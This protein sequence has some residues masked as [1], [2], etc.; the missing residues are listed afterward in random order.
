MKIYN[1]H[2]V[3][4]FFSIIKFFFFWCLRMGKCT[5]RPSTNPSDRFVSGTVGL[6]PTKI[7]PPQTLAHQAPPY[8]LGFG[9]RRIIGHRTGPIGS[10]SPS[11]ESSVQI[12]QQIGQRS[13]LPS[14]RKHR[15]SEPRVQDHEDNTSSLLSQE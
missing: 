14:S 6:E 9:S 12:Q 1:S 7:P 15:V 11:E 13:S 4:F 5:R 2:I 8:P 3:K 10:Y